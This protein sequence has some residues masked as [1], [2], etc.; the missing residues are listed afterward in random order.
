MSSGKQLFDYQRA[1]VLHL[2]QV[3]RGLLLNDMG[4]GKSPVTT[5]TLRVLS[6]SGEDVFPALIVC[7]NTMKGTWAKEWA[8]WWPG[9]RTE[10]LD[11]GK[12]A[13]LAAIDRVATGESQ[14]LITNWESLRGHS[15][16]AS[17][18]ST[19]LRP[20]IRC[21]PALAEGLTEQERS[22]SIN[23]CERCPR[24][25]NA[26]T[27]RSIVADEV[28]RA[29]DPTAKQARALWALATE[30]T[31]IRFALT[32]TPIADA[33]DDLWSALHFIDPVQWPVKTKFVDRW[34]QTVFNP[35][36]G[37]TI[38]GLKPETKEEFFRITDPYVRR[39]PKELVLDQLPPK[40]F[41]TRYVDM[42]PK[43][44]KAYDTMRDDMVTEL[45]HEIG[46]TG[47]TVASSPM[48]Q[49]LR[50]G[51]FASAYAE[52][53]TVMVRDPETGEMVPK[54]KVRLTEPSNKL[55]ALDEILDEMGDKPVVVFA[56]SRQLIELAATRLEKQHILFTTIVGG[57]TSEERT[58]SIARFQNGKVRVMLATIK[59]GGTGITLTR[60]DMLV[61]LNRSW[62]RIENAQAEDR[63]HR[64]GSEIHENVTI[65]DVIT[66]GTVEEGQR[67]RLADKE[68][69]SDE[70]TRD[71]E[72]MIKLLKGAS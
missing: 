12:N 33:P 55:D 22:R 51:Q 32:G 56:E 14:V 70:F 28:H 29:K 11:G 16:L 15:K 42:Q 30:D 3:R 47:R 54:V 72:M 53:Y 63:V 65:V 59:A 58:A 18:G 6:V 62:S 21:Q 71:R 34:C 37:T 48:I 19:R 44:K 36:G 60:A 23:S 4:M 46:V 64:I 39:V 57:Q 66:R 43:Q 31:T 8:T 25:L 1:D 52:L 10:V 50:L 17:Y 49:H 35:F 69:R 5:S 7:P 20:C 26:I 67:D 27:W 38:I 45:E 9:I 40:L 2:A 61:F 24:E 13:R 41:S 68:A